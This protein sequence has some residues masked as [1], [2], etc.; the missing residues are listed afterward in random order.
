[1]P[2]PRVDSRRTT[3]RRPWTSVPAHFG[4]ELLAAGATST[5]Y[6]RRM[7]SPH[8][9]FGDQLADAVS[10]GRRTEFARAAAGPS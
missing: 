1:M 3:T 2:T 10:D 9:G 7:T 8:V 4:R 5:D 6:D